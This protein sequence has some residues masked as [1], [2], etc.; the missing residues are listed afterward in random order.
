MYEKNICTC[1]EVFLTRHCRRWQLSILDQLSTRYL[2][3]L[4]ESLLPILLCNSLFTLSSLTKATYTRTRITVD[5]FSFIEC[6]S[7]NSFQNRDAFSP[8]L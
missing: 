8:E 2:R 5:R 6:P 1:Y 3:V 7:E 4:S